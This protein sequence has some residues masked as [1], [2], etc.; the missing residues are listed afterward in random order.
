MLDHIIKLR[1]NNQAELPLIQSLLKAHT[2]PSIVQLA[3]KNEFAQVSLSTSHQW[4]VNPSHELLTSLRKL[5]GEDQ[6]MMKY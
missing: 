2:G 5:L 3:Y 6:A 1:H 4:Q